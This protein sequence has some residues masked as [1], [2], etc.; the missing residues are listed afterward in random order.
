MAPGEHGPF[1]P[2]LAVGKLTDVEDLEAGAE[3]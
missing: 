2:T 3:Q 1:R